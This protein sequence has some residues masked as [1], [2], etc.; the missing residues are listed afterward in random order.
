MVMT[1]ATGVALVTGL[2]S[3]ERELLFTPFPIFTVLVMAVAG[4]LN[5]A[6]V[7]WSWEPI[8]G[9]ASR[10]ALLALTGLVTGAVGG[11]CLGACLTLFTFTGFPIAVSMVALA[12]DV[13]L[14]NAVVWSVG[15]A[16]DSRAPSPQKAAMQPTGERPLGPILSRPRLLAWVTIVALVS[17][18]DVVYLA[19]SLSNPVRPGLFE[20]PP[21]VLAREEILTEVRTTVGIQNATLLIALLGGDW[22]VRRWRRGDAGPFTPLVLILVLVVALL[23]ILGLIPMLRRIFDA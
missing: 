5:S 7:F 17:V 19:A 22:I 18:F 6:V 23:A 8:Q 3:F 21:R 15:G 2:L 12:I 14:I 1:I 4:L 20:R 11:A 10:G 9:A 13:G 16:A